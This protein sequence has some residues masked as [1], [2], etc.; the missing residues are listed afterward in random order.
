MKKNRLSA[1]FLLLLLPLLMVFAPGCAEEGCTDPN[2]DNYNMDATKDD[3]SCIPARDKFLAQYTVAENCPSGNYT[4][5]INVV[6]GSSSD[7]A[8]VLNNFGDFGV[9]INGTVNGTALTIPNQ[10]ITAQG[11]A[12][13]INGTGN[14]S[15][16]LLIINYSY[17]FAGGGETCS[18]N[19]TKR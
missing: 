12:I 11:I 9:A 1:G 4:Y 13:S 5:D 7:D 3:G 17:N 19:C 8:V 10:N 14:I 6:S 15:N 2:S 18:M 16:N